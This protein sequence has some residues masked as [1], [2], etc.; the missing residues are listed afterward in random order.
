MGPTLL[1][2]REL[3]RDYLLA[4]KIDTYE[5]NVAF[6]KRHRI[7]L[8]NRGMIQLARKSVTSDTFVIYGFY[9]LIKSEMERL[10]IPDRPECLWNLDEMGFPLDP[11]KS[12]T[13]GSIGTK[14]V[15]LT[16]GSNRV[17]ISAL[18]TC[19]ADDSAIDPIIIFKGKRMQRT[20][21]GT[22]ALPDTQYAVT[23]SG[24]MT[25]SVSEDIFKSFAEK[26]KDTHPLLLILDGHLNHTS[27]V[28]IELA[29]QENISFLKL[30]AHCTI[31][32]F[33]NLWMLRV[34]PLSSHTM[35]LN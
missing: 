23:D 4:N 11:S 35:T 8:K 31:R 18:A 6:M 1:E 12:K 17:N 5:G 19:C 24:W 28:T 30:P 29:I 3:V 21:V 34:F 20:W 14:T 9:N 16:H 33:S 2:F 10:Q 22:S 25:N 7:T 26:T 27:L 32:I 13:I 15:R